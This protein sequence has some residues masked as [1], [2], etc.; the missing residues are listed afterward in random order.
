MFIFVVSVPWVAELGRLDNVRDSA[1]TERRD[2][3]N[4]RLDEC[5][6]HGTLVV[7]TLCV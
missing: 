1:I 4:Q 7:L 5:S 6:H 3:Y 2:S